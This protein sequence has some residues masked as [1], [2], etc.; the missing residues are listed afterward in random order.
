M[1]IYTVNQNLRISSPTLDRFK[2]MKTLISTLFILIT[3]SL[4]IPA[5]TAQIEWQK[6][7]NKAQTQAREMSRPL[8]LDFTADWCKPCKMMDAQFWV[9]P[10]VVEA[11]RNFIAVKIDYDREK[12][13]VSRYGVSAIPFVVFADPLGNTVTFRRGFGSKSV[14]EIN[15]IFEEMPKDFSSLKK[16][17][18]AL[19][20]KKDDGAS[21]LQIADAYRNAKMIYLSNSFYKKALKTEEIK[22]DA[23]KKEQIMFILG[24]NTFAVRVDKETTDYLGDFLKE[25]PG[26]KNREIS[27]AMI[28]VS[29]ARMKKSKE[30]AKYLEQLKTEFPQSKN[31]ESV[32]RSV[33]ESKNKN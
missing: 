11:T 21:L 3:A 30:A 14:R 4:P 22:A 5:Q 2:Y 19:D 31:I 9:L 18:D 16:Y 6:D 33:E 28:A 27:L 29:Y 13:L 10:E 23:E 26:S 7:F 1:I 15:Q 25:F 12:S 20:E 24:A 8:L 17:Y 32:S